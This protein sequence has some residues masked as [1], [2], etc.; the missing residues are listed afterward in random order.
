MAMASQNSNPS[1]T[2]CSG[3]LTTEGNIIF[4]Q[5]HHVPQYCDGYAWIPLG[6]YPGTGGLGCASPTGLEGDWIYNADC[7]I[8]QYCDGQDWIGSGREIDTTPSPFSFTDQNSVT[9][10]TLITSNIV[11]I[12]G[13]DCNVPVTI[14]GSGSPEYRICNDG[15]CSSVSQSWINSSGIINNGQYLQLR[16]T[17]HT[18]SNTENLSNVTVGMTT[19]NWGV[20]TTSCP[21]IGDVCSDGSIF[22]GDTN[23]YVTDVNQSTASR[24][25]NSSGTNDINP[26]SNSNGQSNHD[27]RLGILSDFP[28]FSLCESLNRHTNTDWYLPAKDELNILYTNK[29]AIGGFTADVYWS[30]TEDNINNSWFQFFGNGNQSVDPKT[31]FYDV[32]CVRRNL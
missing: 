16:L 8:I 10:S 9:T 22:A 12:A 23:L 30:S 29:A 3:P 4:N 15:T 25:K 28:A 24:W 26:D 17:S 7:K 1:G 5:D 21:D 2:G 13:I 19:E 31:S 20:T 32:R 11:Q 18:N 14:S 27:N 6:P